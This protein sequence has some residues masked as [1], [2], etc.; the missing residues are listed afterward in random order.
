MLA[1]MATVF[2]VPTHELEVEW[3]G[4]QIQLREQGG[5]IMSY[6]DRQE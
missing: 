4:A 6:Y 3:I 2:D 5:I 1:G